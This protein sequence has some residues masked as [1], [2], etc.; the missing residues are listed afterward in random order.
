MEVH[1][2]TIKNNIGLIPLTQRMHFFTGHVPN[3]CHWACFSNKSFLY[4]WVASNL[5]YPVYW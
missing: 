2:I 5:R 4:Q 1:I 3:D